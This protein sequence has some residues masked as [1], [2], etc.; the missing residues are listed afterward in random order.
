MIG[1]CFF[2]PYTQMNLYPQNILLSSQG[3]DKPSLIMSP[4]FITLLIHYS[5]P[6]AS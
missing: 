5:K 3:T 4:S 2:T 1:S 6:N